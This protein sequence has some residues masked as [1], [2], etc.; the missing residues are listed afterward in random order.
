MNKNLTNILH[1]YCKN[2]I[3]NFKNNEIYNVLLN[4]VTDLNLTL[5][6]EYGQEKDNKKSQNLYFSVSIRNE[7]NEIIEIFDDGY[8]TAATMLIS[9]DRKERIKFFSWE[10]EDFID[11]LNW[12]IESIKKLK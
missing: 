4:L 9:V 1:T 10:D 6:C 3:L 11:S 7:N 12:I 8:L 2:E 5:V